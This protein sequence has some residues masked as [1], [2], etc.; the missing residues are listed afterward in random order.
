LAFDAA[1]S[2]TP[3]KTTTSGPLD[4]AEA[5]TTLRSA[6]EPTDWGNL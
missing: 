6:L 4:L 3:W 5:D 2:M 1:A